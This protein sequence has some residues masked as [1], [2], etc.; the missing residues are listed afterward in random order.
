MKI[1]IVEDEPAMN[2]FLV[3]ALK[4]ENHAVDSARDG[5][6]GSFLARTNDYDLIVMDYNLP[7]IS[8]L[9]T[10]QEIR[11]EKVNTPIIVL[12]VCSELNDKVTALESGAD[13]YLTKPFSMAELSARIKAL[14]RRPK[15]KE[16]VHL[17]CGQIILDPE[18]FSA[19]YRGKPLDLT[20][21]EFALLEFMVKNQGRV[22]SRTKLLEG[23]W[24]INGDPFSN[25]IEMHILK[26]RKKL[27]DKKQKIIKT[28]PGRGYKLDEVKA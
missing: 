23:V 19:N 16:I 18:N 9:E 25:T 27:N 6:E 10:I 12:T 22:L 4:S 8:G 28:L 13:D 11:T 1:L 21:K 7:K 3:Q 17:S 14:G 20:G 5:E 24:D 15:A 26:L 2:A